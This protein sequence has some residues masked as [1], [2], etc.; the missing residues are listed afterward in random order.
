MTA[1]YNR[2]RDQPLDSAESFAQRVTA[3]LQP[4]GLIPRGV[5]HLTEDELGDK[6]R[7]IVLVGN[8]G[9]RMWQAFNASNISSL[10][11][12]T[13]SVV[14]RAASRLIARA[15]YPFQGPPYAPFHR[16]ALATG[17]V[18]QSP[19]GLLI[20]PKYGLWHAYR[21]ALAFTA[22]TL[23]SPAPAHESPCLTCAQ[24]PCRSACPVD[25]F[26]ETSF[27]V[28][29]CR[30]HLAGPNG[31]TCGRFGCLARHACPIGVR[32]VYEP[33]QAEFHMRAF[34][35]DSPIRP[36]TDTGRTPVR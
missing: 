33:A 5:V 22:E 29:K 3:E 28:A 13:A 26:Q 20:D 21:A 30:S 17:T 24:K 27:D 2:K 31:T 8:A 4:S 14:D 7:T 1:D 35:R 6:T 15:V 12:W 9:P 32:Y 18:H 36:S 25:A 16:W 19:I 23:P 11:S 34:S 10:D